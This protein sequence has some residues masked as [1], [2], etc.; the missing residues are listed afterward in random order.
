MGINYEDRRAN[1]PAKKIWELFK[2]EI[3]EV[4]QL[5]FE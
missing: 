3:G 1:Q 4:F 2:G 5:T